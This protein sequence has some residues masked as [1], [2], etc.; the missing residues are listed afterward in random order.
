MRL[1]FHFFALLSSVILLAE[2]GEAYRPKQGE[3][4]SLNEAKF[5][6][7]ELVFVDHI[8]R[9][10]SCLLYTSDAADE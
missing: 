3:F 10:G 2:E 7:G 1:A 5:H 6:R 4:P 9:R 8:N